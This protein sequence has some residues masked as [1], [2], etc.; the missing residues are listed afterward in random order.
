MVAHGSERRHGDPERLAV[1]VRSRRSLLD[2]CAR[3]HTRTPLLHAPRA[4]RRLRRRLR[5]ADRDRGCVLAVLRRQVGGS[6]SGAGHH[7]QIIEAQPAYASALQADRRER[8]PD[9]VSR[10]DRVHNPRGSAVDREAIGI[11]RVDFVES[12]TP[13]RLGQARERARCV[14]ERDAELLATCPHHATL[15]VPARPTG[16]RDLEVDHIAVE[17]PRPGLVR[18]QLAR[19]E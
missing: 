18:D 9:A 3:A 12:A 19:R 10:G 7:S 14:V 17:Q 13:T 6:G 4:H 1:R 16:Y 5:V 2:S 8:K 11:D 15:E